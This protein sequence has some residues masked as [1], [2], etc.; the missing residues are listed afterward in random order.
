MSASVDGLRR[1]V[2]VAAFIIFVYQM[3]AAAK[4]YNEKLSMSSVGKVFL[5]R[6]SI[7]Q[8]IIVL[9]DMI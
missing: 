4:K 1:I 3:V 5:L 6:K 9:S 8:P 2:L 7:I